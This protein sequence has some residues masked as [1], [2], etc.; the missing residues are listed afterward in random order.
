MKEYDS[1]F[2]NRDVYWKWYL[3]LGNPRLKCKSSTLKSL[4]K[5]RL[6]NEI[7]TKNK[8]NIEKKNV[9]HGEVSGT[10]FKSKYKT[11]LT[12]GNILVFFT[13]VITKYL[14]KTT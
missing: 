4:T 8:A 14:T 3:K 7:I 1:H 6:G 2:I 5:Y 10:N 11:A 9:R 13:I 12:L